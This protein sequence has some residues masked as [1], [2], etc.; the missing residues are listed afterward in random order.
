[1]SDFHPIPFHL[2]LLIFLPIIA[3]GSLYLVFHL[4]IICFSEAI[5][6]LR[7]DY[8]HP[9]VCRFSHARFHL[10]IICFLA[11][12]WNLAILIIPVCDGY[13][14][15][16]FNIPILELNQGAVLTFLN[17]DQAGNLNEGWPTKKANPSFRLRSI[18]NINEE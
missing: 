3:G 17:V 13:L 1:M 16:D 4:F 9:S 7:I 8:K 5:W 2:S 6:N 15:L 12:I 11:V 10:F 14:M 18:K